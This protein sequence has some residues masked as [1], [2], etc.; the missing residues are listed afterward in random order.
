MP[1]HDQL[2]MIKK[3]FHI[4]LALLLLAATTGVTMHKHYC[5]GR[6]K[7]VVVFEKAD[8]CMLSKG[9]K[10]KECPKAC[11]EHEEQKFKVDNLNKASFEYQFAPKVH[12]SV[13]TY[14]LVNFDLLAFAPSFKYQNY[15]P[16]LLA[17][18]V[19]VLVQSFLL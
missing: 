5:M 11:C 9:L 4:V 12:L 17:Q 3:S 16:P 6:L 14:L 2:K 8:S 18:D 10:G 19:P 7:S 15:K 13:L 1:L